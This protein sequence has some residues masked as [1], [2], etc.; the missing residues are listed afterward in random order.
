[1]FAGETPKNHCSIR[2]IIFVE[3][4][5]ENPRAMLNFTYITKRNA[6]G[7]RVTRYGSPRGIGGSGGFTGPPPPPTLFSIKNPVGFLMNHIK[8]LDEKEP[9]RVFKASY[10]ASW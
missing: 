2:T 3:V 8:D 6:F 10:Q 5:D 7:V 9:S 1:M 4:R